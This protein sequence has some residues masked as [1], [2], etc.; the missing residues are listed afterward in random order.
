MGVMGASDQYPQRGAE[1]ARRILGKSVS[2][3]LCGAGRAG[4]IGASCR[5]NVPDQGSRQYRG[6]SAES[7]GR[8]RPRGRPQRHRRYP[9]QHSLH[10]AIAAGDARAHGRQH[11]RRHHPHRQ[12][13][14]RDG[15]RQPAPVRHPGHP[16][17]RHG[18]RARRLPRIC[19]AA[20][21][22]SPR[23]SAPTAT[24]MRWRRVRSR[25]AA[26]RPKGRPPAS[27]A[28]CRRSAG[29]PT[30]PSSNARSS[31][32]STA[33]PMCGSRLR[34]ADFTTAKRIA[35]A[36]NDY[37]GTKTAEPI[38]PSTVQLSIP[39]EFKGNVVA[40][41]TEI[42]QLQVEPD[43]AAKIIIDERSGIIVMGRDVRVATVAVAQ[44]NLTVSISESPQVSQPNLL[45]RG[46]TVVT[47]RTNVACLRGRQETCAGERR[48]IAAAAR[49]RP[50]RARH[51]TARPD[52]HSAGDQGG[53]RDPGR[54]RG[55]V[56]QPA[57]IG[58]NP[59]AASRQGADPLHQRPA[60]L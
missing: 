43:L 55:D 41:L 25:S 2:A 57:P 17:G 48:R 26:S 40:F 28:A 42:E 56:M 58:S 6:R 30:A 16:H 60:R 37:L 9:Q 7:A 11:P 14:R 29:S 15:H 59:N 4:A 1:D 50:Q 18:F 33:C 51:R 8:L 53:R 31:S 13:R 21:C 20:P 22:S 3:G 35:A 12:R 5:R 54:H 45:A 34:N 49:R 27:P 24:S 44:G 19:K 32:R 46:R 38:D 36:V 23:C 39:T 10:Q 52:R 47:P